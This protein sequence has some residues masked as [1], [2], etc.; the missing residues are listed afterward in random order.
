[1]R[2][3]TRLGVPAPPLPV[4]MRLLRIGSRASIVEL[5]AP[6]VGQGRRTPG[7]AA[8][9]GLRSGRE[10]APLAG[11]ALERLDAAV[12]ELEAGAGHKVLHSARH[13]HLA[14][15]GQGRDPGG[16]VHGHARHVLV[17][18]F[19]L[20]CVETR[21]HLDPQATDVVADGAGG[22]D[23]PAGSDE[24]GQEPVT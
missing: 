20:A 11:N 6:C 16:D 5:D 19:A 9:A 8:E 12:V 10:E 1:M 13:E 7:I 18:D 22:G 23:G 3:R 24:R 2:Y 15:P 14:G 17:Q 4:R 21:S